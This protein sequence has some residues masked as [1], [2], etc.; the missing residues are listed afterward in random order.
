M[1]EWLIT[2]Y[3]TMELYA[4]IRVEAE[5]KEEALELGKREIKDLDF[6]DWEISDDEIYPAEIELVEETP[7]PSPQLN[8]PVLPGLETTNSY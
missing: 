4:E 6:E 8:H 7:D 1:D 3:R 5:T 2:Q